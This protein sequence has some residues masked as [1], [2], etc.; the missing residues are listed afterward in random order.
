MQKA[1]LKTQKANERS[2][3]IYILIN[4]KQLKMREKNQWDGRNETNEM[5][6]MKQSILEWEKQLTGY[7]EYEWAKSL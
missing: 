3:L 4:W 5:T 7:G 2:R 1:N 6:K